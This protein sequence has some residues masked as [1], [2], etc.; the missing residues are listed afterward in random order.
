MNQKM[1]CPLSTVGSGGVQDHPKNSLILAHKESP[2]FL[3]LPCS[4]LLA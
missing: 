2:S 4:V 3:G 1:A